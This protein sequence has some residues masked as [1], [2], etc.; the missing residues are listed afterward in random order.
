MTALRDF[1]ATCWKVE[2]PKLRLESGELKVGVWEKRYRGALQ[3][4][5][6]WNLESGI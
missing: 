3:I 1:S 5:I 2:S 6:F 4:Q